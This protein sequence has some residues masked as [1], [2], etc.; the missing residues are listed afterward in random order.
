MGVFA[1]ICIHLYTNTDVV[2]THIFDTQNYKSTHCYTNCIIVPSQPPSNV[3]ASLI[4]RAITV[5][6]EAL[7]IPTLAEE[8]L[9]YKVIVLP[10]NPEQG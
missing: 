5:T 10:N 2:Y 7:E 9:G 8:I 6:W 4:G 3:V 1:R